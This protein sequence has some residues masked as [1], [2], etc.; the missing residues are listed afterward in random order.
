MHFALC[1]IAFWVGKCSFIYAGCIS[2]VNA[3]PLYAKSTLGKCIFYIMRNVFGE[4]YCILGWGVDAFFALC[5]NAF[6]ADKQFR[7]M[8]HCISC[9][10]NTFPHMWKFISG[11]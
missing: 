5:E 8:R 2:G 4:V 9:G 1:E 11:R 3:F 7:I 6:R 10:T